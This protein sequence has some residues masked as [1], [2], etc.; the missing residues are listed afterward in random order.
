MPNNGDA[1]RDY[2][3]IKQLV[4]DKKGQNDRKAYFYVLQMPECGGN[5][6]KIGKSSNIYSRFKYYNEHFHNSQVLIHRLR[7]F[8]NS[9][10]DRYTD[11]A[12]K[13]YALF[14]REAIYALRQFNKEK[15]KSGLG[16]L[17]EWFEPEYQN[18]LLKHF[19]TFVDDFTNMKFDKTIK[20]KGL[21][22]KTNE[23]LSESES[24]Q[25]E[26]E[27][28]YITPS[29]PRRKTAI[30]KSYNPRTG[31]NKNVT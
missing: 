4:Q 30:R 23:N 22:S 25:D 21:R 19:D 7:V 26:E 2:G 12:M 9:I 6:I 17:T 13:L 14:E 18:E 31:K 10:V 29:R 5:R 3:T 20:R 15:T 16:V 27:Q 28:I 8:N 1:V 24:S 11:K